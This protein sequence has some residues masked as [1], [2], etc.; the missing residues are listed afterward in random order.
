MDSILEERIQEIIRDYC[1]RYYNNF[2]TP[3][4]NLTDLLEED[5]FLTDEIIGYDKSLNVMIYNN[6]DY[7]IHVLECIDDIIERSYFSLDNG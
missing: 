3:E 1:I 7:T 2:N 6:M 5:F 4:D